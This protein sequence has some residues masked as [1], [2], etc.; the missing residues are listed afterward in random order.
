MT[1]REKLKDFIKSRSIEDVV[2]LFYI[3]GKFWAAI[4]VALCI[5]TFLMGFFISEKV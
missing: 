4:C 1:T 3:Y 2:N 5:I